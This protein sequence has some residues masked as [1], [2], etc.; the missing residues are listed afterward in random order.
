M[1]TLSI[2]EIARH[3]EMPIE[4]IRSYARHFALYVPAVRTGA[5]IRYP[6]AGAMLLGEI[7]DAVQAGASFEEIETAL[8][9][10]IPVTVVGAP[11]PVVDETTAAA[12][13]EEILRLLVDQQRGLGDLIEGLATADQFHGLRAE[14]ASLA[15]VLAQRDSQLVHTNAVIVAELREAFRLLRQE[16][17]E[18]RT[19]LRA[20]RPQANTVT[21]IGP[22]EPPP[23]EQTPGQPPARPGG[24]PQRKGGGRTPR[25]MGQ[26][27][28]LNGVVQN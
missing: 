23:S 26:P 24:P 12:P 3:L 1:D 5:E 18:L 11:E 2:E 13:E 10:H 17:A 27:L 14:T 15:A 16:I 28:R 4:A 22:A 25:R 19:D 20:E 21:S 9:A 6:P 7:A 8:Q